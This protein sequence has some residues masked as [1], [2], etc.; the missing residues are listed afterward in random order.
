MWCEL[1]WS[2]FTNLISLLNRRLVHLLLNWI[3]SEPS[4]RNYGTSTSIISSTP[5]LIDNFSILLWYGRDFTKFHLKVSIRRR[6]LDHL[7]WIASL[8]R[9]H[10]IDMPLILALRQLILIALRTNLNLL[11][12][13]SPTHIVYVSTNFSIVLTFILL[14]QIDHRPMLV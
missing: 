4:S 2:I 6:L 11:W 3:D 9:H 8:L 12:I 5:N 1:I 13:T 14:L 10:K 7:L